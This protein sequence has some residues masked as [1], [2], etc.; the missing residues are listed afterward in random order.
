MKTGSESEQIVRAIRRGG[1]DALVVSGAQGDQVVV[2]QGADHPYRVLVENLSDGAA[3]LDSEGCIVY[4]NDRFAQL[5]ATPSAQIVGAR[6]IDLLPSI[7]GEELARMIRKRSSG[8]VLAHAVAEPQRTIRF[9][10]SPVNPKDSSKRTICVLATEVTDMVRITEALKSTEHSVEELSSR[11]L[12]LQDEE[13]RRMARDLHDITGQSL[14]A[15]SMMLGSILEY[16]ANLNPELRKVIS[17]CAS[18]NE[19]ITNEIRTL[20]YLL[21]PPLIEERGLA[22]AVQ[23]YVEGFSLRSN[24]DISVEVDPDFPRLAPAAE[25]ALFRIVQE[26]LTNVHRYSGASRGSV[27]LHRRDTGIVLEIADFGKGMSPDIL[28]SKDSK[29]ALGVGILGMRERV[30]QLS[31]S[32]EIISRPNHGT[33]VTVRLPICAGATSASPSSGPG[34]ES[35]SHKHPKKARAANSGR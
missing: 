8:V 22:S 35:I 28:G 30:R 3:T 32:L 5:L 31:G 25:I 14:A 11:L 13:R 34:P 10:V 26:S 16:S 6:L 7:D 12:S 33:R 19:Q 20:S 21:H 23:W 4:A 27:K 29:P 2:L 24:I 18:I 9:T 1:V 17:E 15:Q